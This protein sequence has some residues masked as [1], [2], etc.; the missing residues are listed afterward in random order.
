[1]VVLDTSF[2]IDLIRNNSEAV[3]V[4]EGLDSGEVSIATPTIVELVRGLGSKNVRVH[5]KEKVFELI[6]SFNILDLDKDCAILAGGIEDSLRKTGDRIDIIDIMIGAITIENDDV[7]ITR[8]TRH[9]QRINGL[10]CREY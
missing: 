4:S 7:L 5:E 2:I 9:F 6:D 8:N 1:M 10:N 3:R